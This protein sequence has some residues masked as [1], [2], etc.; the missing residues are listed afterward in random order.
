MK[1][2]LHA[3]LTAIGVFTDAETKRSQRLAVF[4][5]AIIGTL[6]LV[7]LVV[8]VI[9]NTTCEFNNL[10]CS[11]FTQKSVFWTFQS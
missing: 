8:G 4:C 5:A 11:T 1:E 6:L 10:L 9:Y 2:L 3:V 7:V